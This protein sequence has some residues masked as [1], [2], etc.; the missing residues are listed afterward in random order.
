M[1]S[2]KSKHDSSDER[3]HDLVRKLQQER[4]AVS[5]LKESLRHE[6][7]KTQWG[8]AL[9]IAAM[10]LGGVAL[11]LLL[12]RNAAIA[13]AA[14]KRAV[15]T[16]YETTLADIRRRSALDVKK[17]ENFS[18]EALA[19]DLL[20]VVDNLEYASKHAHGEETS[21]RTLRG[22]PAHQSEGNLEN[23]FDSL[24][25]GVTLTEKSILDALS[26]HGIEKQAPISQDF[27]PNIYEAVL[28]VPDAS[29]RPG[30]VAQVFRS[31][32]LIHGRVLRAAQV[33]VSVSEKAG[34]PQKAEAAEVGSSAEAKDDSQPSTGS[35]EGPRSA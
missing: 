17:A 16:E 9:G 2:G 3:N 10:G 5:R 28:Q 8:I 18:I 30:V 25:E 13:T 23:R 27:D 29:V 14:A 6:R 19:R 34:L 22:A 7:E 24:A 15:A 33:G 12:R 20:P 11:T 4:E 26:K 35:E 21:G 31:G 1:G 32:F